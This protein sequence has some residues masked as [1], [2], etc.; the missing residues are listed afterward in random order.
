MAPSP[1]SL[2]FSNP[3]LN[4]TPNPILTTVHSV[5]QELFVGY[6]GKDVYYASFEQGDTSDGVKIEVKQNGK[7]SC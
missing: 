7:C 2:F 3:P 4:L 5:N 1:P 6:D